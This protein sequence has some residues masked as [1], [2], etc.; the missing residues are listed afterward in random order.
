M[1]YGKNVK[2]GKE[3]FLNFN[4]TFIDT[5]MITIGSRT[6]VGPNVS[7]YS[8]SHPLDPVLR[9]GMKGPEY[10]KEI[11]VGEDCWLGG[12]VII[13]PGVSLGYGVVVG[14][15]SVVTKVAKSRPCCISSMADSCI[16]RA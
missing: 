1:D 7:F 16:E 13:L 4:C 6:L 2:L 11:D 5:C 3:V 12:H 10:G 14:A 15:G 9:N 8:G